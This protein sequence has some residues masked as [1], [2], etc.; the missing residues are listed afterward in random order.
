VIDYFKSGK[1][2]VKDMITHRFPF[3]EI[4]EALRVIEDPAIENG[5]VVLIF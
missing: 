1:L 2:Q 3:T 5:K 4:H